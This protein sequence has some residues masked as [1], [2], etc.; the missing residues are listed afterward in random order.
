MITPANKE[1][2]EL[3]KLGEMPEQQKIDLLKIEKMKK[4]EML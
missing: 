4:M 2:K 3:M 1:A